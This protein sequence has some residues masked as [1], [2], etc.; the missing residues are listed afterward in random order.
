MNYDQAKAIVAERAPDLILDDH[1]GHAHVVVRKTKG[2]RTFSIM[3]P[4][5]RLPLPIAA[6]AAV[7][8]IAATEENPAFPALPE[9]L[10]RSSESL[11]AEAE[12]KE[13]IDALNTAIR[14][15]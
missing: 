14:H 12:L 3:L 4:N 5:H 8:A 15:L 10:A 9:V 1:E 11:H 2:G 13:F 7:P 6:R